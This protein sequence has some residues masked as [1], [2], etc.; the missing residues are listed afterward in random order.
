MEASTKSANDSR[1]KSKPDAK[2]FANHYAALWQRIKGSFDLN[3][4]RMLPLYEVNLESAFEW[5]RRLPPEDYKEFFRNINKHE[6]ENSDAWQMAVSRFISD[7]Y[8][9]PEKPPEP[10]LDYRTIKD[11]SVAV[12]LHATTHKFKIH[13]ADKRE[14]VWAVYQRI[15]NLKYGRPYINASAKYIIKEAGAIKRKEAMHAIRKYNKM[16]DRL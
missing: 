16:R 13:D 4:K 1:P 7:K 14:L 3:D 6:L 2:L 12:L 11:E 9:V 15:M 5:S 10:R 8:P